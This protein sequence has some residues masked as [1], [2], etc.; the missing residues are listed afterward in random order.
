MK[1][2]FLIGCFLLAAV[3]AGVGVAVLSRP[4]AAVPDAVARASGGQAAVAADDAALRRVPRPTKF[5][6]PKGE[7]AKPHLAVTM[8]AADAAETDVDERASWTPDER[9]LADKIE[10]ALD[11]EDFNQIVAC[12]SV[13]LT[14]ARV[15]IRQSMVDALGW[16]GGRA[17][18]ELTPFLADADADVRDSALMEWSSAISDVEDD[19]ERIQIVSMAMQALSDEEQLE[20]I[21]NE[22][23]GVDEKLAVESLLG[24]VE[25]GG[26]AAGI[27]KAKETYEFVTGEEFT[28]RADAER[29]LAE[30]YEPPE[31]P[32]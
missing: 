22:Y 11:E 7:R 25:A 30:E 1:K 4:D 10:K 18:P 26:T 13:A 5:R 21:A 24:V 3:A 6:A 27:A 20:D 9:R 31:K 8:P 15:E 19:A 23:I 29:W 14:S 32:E 2:K 16:F 12:A 28:N 17:L